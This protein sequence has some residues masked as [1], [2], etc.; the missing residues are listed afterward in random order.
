M[1]GLART[2]RQAQPS[3]RGWSEWL[4][5]A[6]RKIAA[7]GMLI[8]QRGQTVWGA[9]KSCAGDP[10]GRLDSSDFCSFP[11]FFCPGSVYRCTKSVCVIAF[12]TRNV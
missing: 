9:S 12:T 1:L 11:F 5:A 8:E 6:W 2:R 4:L 7:V 10:A 3:E